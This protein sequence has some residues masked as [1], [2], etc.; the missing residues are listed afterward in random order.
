M[1]YVSVLF[2]HLQHILTVPWY[3]DNRDNFGHYNRSLQLFIHIQV[4]LK[5]I[6]YREK[7]IFLFYEYMKV[8]LFEVTKKYF[9]HDIQFFWDAPVNMFVCMYACMNERTF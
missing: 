7:L 2:E 4:N 1:I 8:S 3:T 6:E 5:Q 9:F